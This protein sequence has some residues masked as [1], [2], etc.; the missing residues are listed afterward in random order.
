VGTLLRRRSLKI[1]LLVAGL[2]AG[3][4]ASAGADLPPLPPVPPVLTVPTLPVLP[5]PPRAPEVPQVPPAPVLPRAP[6]APPVSRPSLPVGGGGSRSTTSASANAQSPSYRAAGP[7]AKSSTRPAK[8]Y[9]PHFSRDWISRTG[10]KQRRQTTLIFVLRKA[11]LVEFVV[12]Q[13]VPDCRQVGRF[14]VQGR[15]GVNRVRFR[16]RI[17]R[18]VL[19]PG[20]YRIKARALPG[21]RT[22]IDTRLVVVT[23]ASK[24]EI[25]VARSAD[26]CGSSAGHLDSSR[27][28]VGG[29]SGA[30]PVKKSTEATPPSGEAENSGGVLGTRFTKRAV[31]AVKSIPLWLFALLGLAIALLAIAALPL[32]ATPNGRAAAVLAHRRGMIALAGASAL[33]AFTVAYALS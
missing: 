20:T 26:T 22:V 24:E 14:R 19:G 29:S 28:T 10:P 6:A 16:G 30:P 31:D 33:A 25:A 11:A 17:G 4:A 18:R 8:V 2:L 1:A 3:W 27:S 7:G 5:P 12:I 32:R 9:R 21:R 13:V 15:R 23:R